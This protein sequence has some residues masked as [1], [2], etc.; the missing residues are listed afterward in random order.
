M[1][2]PIELDWTPKPADWP[3]A[4]SAMYAAVRWRWLLVAVMVAA[5]VVA[6]VTSYWSLGVVALVLA[7]MTAVLP[8]APAYFAFARNP[9]ASERIQASVDADGIDMSVGQMRRRLAWSTFVRW[10]ELRNSFVLR[11]GTESR[12]P[13]MIV[14]KRAFAAERQQDLRDLLTEHIA[15]RGRTR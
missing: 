15:P 3:E 8:Y 11:M 12:D 1:P 6:F 4:M 10:Y 9:L 2:E 5:A 13:S 14:P 7:A